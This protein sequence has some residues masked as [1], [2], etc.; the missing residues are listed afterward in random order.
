VKAVEGNRFVPAALRF[1]SDK[2]G[3]TLLKNK[4]RVA[5]HLGK[6]IR[7]EALI[8]SVRASGRKSGYVNVDFS[9]LRRWLHAAIPEFMLALKR[10]S[11][12][13]N[14]PSAIYSVR[15]VLRHWAEIS[16]AERWEALCLAMSPQGLAFQLASLRRKFYEKRVMDGAALTTCTNNWQS[17]VVFLRYLIEGKILPSFDTRAGYISAPGGGSI[18]ADRNI[19]VQNNQSSFNSPKNFNAEADSYN[20]DLFITMSIIESNETYLDT[21]TDL[22]RHALATIKKCARDQFEELIN[23][24]SEGGELLA[25][26]DSKLL[27]I[28]KDTARRRRY[29][30]PDCGRHFFEVNGGHPNLLGNILVVVAREM[31]GLP[32]PHR[33]YESDGI[34]IA[35][36][37]PYPYWQ[38]VQKYGK[39]NLLPY[40]GVM[41]SETAVICILLLMLDC[42]QLN[43]SSLYRAKIEDDQGQPRLISIAGEHEEQTRLVVTK[44]RAGEEKS[45]RLSPFCE[46]VIQKVLEWTKPVREEMR[47]QGKHEEANFLWVGVSGLH[48]E[49]IAYSEKALLGAL[50]TN[51][52]HNKRGSTANST[53][54][55][56]FAERYPEVRP[57]ANK[58]TFKAIRVNSGVL[59]Y[60]ET[61]GDL[62]ATARAFG[63]KNVNTT[64]TNYIPPALRQVIYERQI[65]RHQNYLIV[66]SLGFEDEKLRASDFSTIE[67]LH[68]FLQGFATPNDKVKDNAG[69]VLAHC[70]LKAE[71]NS[72]ILSED[73][74]AL[75]VAML[76][77]EKLVNAS[78]KFL[79]T[80][81][82]R[83]G[84]K[85]RFWVEFVDAL[86]ADL[87]LSMKAF[88]QLAQ[89]AR[90]LKSRLVDK[91]RLPEVW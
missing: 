30:D 66:S 16:E 14:A 89:S 62:V 22:L 64:I 15:M 60:L 8:L 56:R 73:P 13:Y 4:T 41:S 17:F 23:L 9:F 28:V 61:D 83:T 6:E 57:W 18:L 77:R 54:L 71:K 11:R 67:E 24:Q 40:L 80:P 32:R 49:L 78:P 46:M 50:K 70:N 59:R 10:F 53:R 27:E 43:A 19:L 63:H 76:Y 51:L 26:T 25:N 85:P 12:P 88:A 7:E 34:S 81:D 87:P 47:R 37:S 45:A 31:G 72:V 42:P 75:A 35:S 2:T 21:Y 39:N 1:S 82:K 33:K 84:V 20:D 90:E 44:P 91:I 69:S 65:R 74:S 29:I 86:Q 48:Y 79:E 68:G 58:L 3:P 55:L 5:R 38:F 36:K 52:V